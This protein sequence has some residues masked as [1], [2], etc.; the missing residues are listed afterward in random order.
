MN[1]PDTEMYGSAIING[2]TKQYKR[3]YSL[4]DYSP[5]LKGSVSD[6]DLGI[7]CVWTKGVTDYFNKDEIKAAL[8][9][10]TTYVGVWQECTGQITYNSES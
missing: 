9:V 8:H 10:N 5:W 2:E 3:Y 4:Q 7:P 1:I 6:D